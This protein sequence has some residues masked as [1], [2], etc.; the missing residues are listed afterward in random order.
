[1][2]R[3]T[4]CM[5]RS[6]DV[7]GCT[8][9]VGKWCAPC[10]RAIIRHAVDAALSDVDAALSRDRCSVSCPFCRHPFDL[11]TASPSQ[12][13]ASLADRRVAA[14]A[15]ALQ[16]CA[17]EMHRN[18]T[19]ET[20]AWTSSRVELDRIEQSLAG[21]RGEIEASLATIDDLECQLAQARQKRRFLADRQSVDLCQEHI[22]ELTMQRE[23]E[24][25]QIGHLE[26]LVEAELAAYVAHGNIV[27]LQSVEQTTLA[28][29][30]LRTLDPLFDVHVHPV[31]RK[32]DEVTSP[33][34]FFTFLPLRVRWMHGQLEAREL[35][36]HLCGWFALRSDLL[37][38]LDDVR[39]SCRAATRARTGVRRWLRRGDALRGIY[40]DVVEQW[41]AHVRAAC[42][43][44]RK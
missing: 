12:P 34:G 18:T 33:V 9:C 29:D 7:V 4:L 28:S 14:M 42:G 25:C 37:Y 22:D 10:H 1:M 24:W 27:Q 40:Y 11:D 21:L 30:L 6:T 36:H 2:M 23:W 39:R 41:Q 43:V 20:S 26:A 5:H 3:C 31:V 15:A 17:T 35:L 19:D 13:P 8:R 38:L 44:H 16:Q 32:W